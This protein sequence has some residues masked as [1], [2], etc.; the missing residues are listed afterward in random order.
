MSRTRKVELEKPFHCILVR[1][2][3][4]KI[5]AMLGLNHYRAGAAIELEPANAVYRFHRKRK[6][7]VR[8]TS[9]CKPNTSMVADEIAQIESQR[10]RNDM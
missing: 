9:R 2:E 1:I 8:Q 10:K 7:D 5:I 4:K 6:I 3:R